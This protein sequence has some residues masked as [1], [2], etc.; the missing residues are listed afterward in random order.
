MNQQV[1]LLLALSAVVTASPVLERE[2]RIVG[3]SDATLGQFPYQVSLRVSAE[4][5]HLCGASLINNRWCLSAA[6]CTVHH[7]PS[8]LNIVV[9]SILVSSGGVSHTL[10]RIV[11]HPN[12]T[13]RTIANDVSLMKT[14]TVIVFTANIQPI[15]LGSAQVGGGVNSIVTGW[16]RI[17]EDGP[18]PDNLQNLTTRTLNNLECKSYFGA[19]NANLIFDHKI[20]ALTRI[21]EGTCNMDSGGPLALDGAVIGIVSWGLGCAA[22]TPDVYD[23]VSYFRTW[24]VNTIA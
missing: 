1:F 2:G 5:R 10:V 12:W 20:C 18:L 24:I 3:G 8:E 9:G 13:S 14:T 22:G 16:G 21:G 7:I 15:A 4:N 17:A 6:H 23:R 11:N 19:A